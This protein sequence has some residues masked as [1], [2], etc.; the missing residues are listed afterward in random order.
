MVACRDCTL[1]WGKWQSSWL[2]YCDGH[3]VKDTPC[4]GVYRQCSCRMC[5]KGS[6]SEMKLGASMCPRTS[7][8]EAKFTQFWET[9][10]GDPECVCAK[11]EGNRPNRLGGDRSARKKSQ[12]HEHTNVRTSV[13]PARRSTEYLPYTTLRAGIIKNDIHPCSC[14]GF[15][16]K[17]EQLYFRIAIQCTQSGD[18][19]LYL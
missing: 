15:Q 1:I 12:T 3:R 6:Y 7:P 8:F 4:K 11:F 17:L 13:H 2:F 10:V 14:A 5:S 16:W 19:P 18:P 9:Q